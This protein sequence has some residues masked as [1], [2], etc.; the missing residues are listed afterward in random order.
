VWYTF[1]KK[2]TVKLKKNLK[3]ISAASKSSTLG[4]R[5]QYFISKMTCTCTIFGPESAYIAPKQ[6]Y[7]RQERNG[8]GSVEHKIASKAVRPSVRWRTKIISFKWSERERA[9][10]RKTDSGGGERAEKREG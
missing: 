10:V 3:E 9:R 7:R 8:D 6:H 2:K 5:Y 1:L 4:P